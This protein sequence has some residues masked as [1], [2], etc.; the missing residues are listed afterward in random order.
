[1]V[2]QRSRGRPQQ[3]ERQGARSWRRTAASGLARPEERNGHALRIRAI[4]TSRA[5]VLVPESNP[6]STN[7]EHTPETPRFGDVV[8]VGFHTRVLMRVCQFSRAA[9]QQTPST[10]L[11][12][13]FPSRGTVQTLFYRPWP[14]MPSAS[15]AHAALRAPKAA[16]CCEQL[17]HSSGYPQARGRKYGI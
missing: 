14:A 12:L 15:S 9:A 2:V 3:S 4:A 8:I 11:V 17:V 6:D 13:R 16:F 1:M 10:R 7:G 5:A